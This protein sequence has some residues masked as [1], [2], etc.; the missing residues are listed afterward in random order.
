MLI[1]SFTATPSD[2]QSPLKVTFVDTSEIDPAGDLV[3]D[4]V[5]TVSEG[6]DL[7]VQDSMYFFYQGSAGD[8]NK[9]MN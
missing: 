6:A 7:D 8:I 5:Y 2:G 3:Q 9:V 1:S 4:V